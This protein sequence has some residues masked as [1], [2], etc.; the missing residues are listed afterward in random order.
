ML[1]LGTYLALVTSV[2]SATSPSFSVSAPAQAFLAPFTGRVV[3]Y[4]SKRG[5][6][7][8]FGPD[9]FNPQPCYSIRVKNGRAGDSFIVD[10]EHAVGFPGK[11]SELAPGVYT[12]QAVI[13]RNQGGRAIG[14]TPGNLYSKPQ[15]I[16]ISSG[17][18]AISLVCDQPV[19]EPA[20]VDTDAV[21]GVR[22]RS[23]LL[24]GFYGHE[25]TLKAAVFLPESS[26]PN[27]RFP[28]IYEVPGFGGT[29]QQFSGINSRYG[30]NRN[31]QK[32][33][34]VILDPNCPTG[35]SVFADSANN[36]PWGKALTTE[37]IPY[38]E[39]K[40]PAIGQPW[41]RFTRGHSSGGW[42]SLWLQVAYPDFFGGCWSTSPDPVDF[43]RFQ[44][45]D[46]Y[47]AHA[48]AYRK[49]DG[50]ATGIARQ[51]GKMVVTVEQFSKMEL[52]I[53]GEQLGSFD[54]VFGPKGADGEP[55]RLYNPQTGAIDPKVAE[56]W[57]K[58]DIWLKFQRE[59]KTLGPKLKGKVHIF[60]GTEDTFYLD[61]AVRILKENLKTLGS[62]AE[63]EL[64]PGDHGSMMTPDL[65]RKIDEEIA[66]TILSHKKG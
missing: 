36:G 12:V 57:K 61:L 6:E 52:P 49:P 10:D 22:L 16:T 28:V 8:R 23:T 30:T 20:F 45:V 44:E 34:H 63:V 50:E 27:E 14:E 33:I 54:A 37:L 62:D 15:K 41:A 58:Y 51:N 60:M 7:P 56:Y 26:D 40:F 32:V 43:R 11:L 9:W 25:V 1:Q 5:G 65:R 48:N 29:A 66:S 4:L 38:I 64:V 35:H 18:E 24:S 53:R 39:S 2:S 55:V 47:A 19:R 3:V 31:G 59:W 13:D 42:S 17:T 46:I 21:K